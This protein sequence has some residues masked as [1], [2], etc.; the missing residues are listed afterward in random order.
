MSQL[1]GGCGGA[2]WCCPQPRRSPL[3]LDLQ[4]GAASSHLSGSGLKRSH[5][6]SP[7]GCG[8]TVVARRELGM[9]LL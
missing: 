9:M 7:P 1:S 6:S 8:G 3:Q 4:L 2:M 5:L